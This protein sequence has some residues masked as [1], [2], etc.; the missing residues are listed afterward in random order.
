MALVFLGTSDFAA[1]VLDALV[2]AN[3]APRLVVGAPS[4]PKGRGLVPEDPPTIATAKRHGIDT[5]QP[6]RINADE[7]ISR[8]RE[9]APD[10]LIVVAYGQILS[11]TV[12]G[13][14]PRGAVNLHGSILPSYRGPAPVARAIQN[15]ESETGVTLQ[16][17]AREVDAGDIV[18]ISRT[19]IREDETAGE[20]SARLS[21]L[22]AE[23][24]LSQLDG[25]LAGTSP[26]VPQDHSRAT[27]APLLEKHEG[28]IDWSR[29]ARMIHDHVRAMSPW[30]GATTEWSTKGGLQKLVLR[31]TRWTDGDAR[32]EPPGSVV[33]I[34]G[35]IEVA[36][37]RGTLLI[38]RLL[39]QGKSELS[40]S[41]FL[42]GAR[43]AVGE[44]FH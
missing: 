28:R 6:E 29:S 18:A 34:A 7:A 9:A 16:Y 14:A 43:I 26:R 27:R 44:R 22:A 39:R 2:R 1:T 41:E 3:R 31:R 38:D 8:L 24:L 37:G 40:A 32:G 36:A 25:L 10:L 35:S 5:F 21:V 23:L 4:R 13:L 12:L 30:P 33:S 19:A 17:M 11:K 20:L 15:G 42:R